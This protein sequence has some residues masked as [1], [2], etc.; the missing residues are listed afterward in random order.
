M[1]FNVL[2]KEMQSIWI[3]M[4]IVLIKLEKQWKYVIPMER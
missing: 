4:Q 1:V 2:I 3:F